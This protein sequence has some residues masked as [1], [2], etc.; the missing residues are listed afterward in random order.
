MRILLI[1]VLL[2][3]LTIAQTDPLLEAVKENYKSNGVQCS[4]DVHIEV[5]GLKMPDKQLFIKFSPDSKPV[6]KGEGMMLVPKKGLLGQFNEVL[7][8]ESQ[9]IFLGNQGD[10]ALYKIVSLNSES[11]W[12]TADVKIYRPD[13]RIYFMDIF[14]KEYGSF[15]VRHRYGQTVMPTVSVITFEAEAFKLPVK[16]LGRGN[17]E[18]LPTD[19]DG[20]VRGRVTLQYSDVKL[21]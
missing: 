11:D 18:D 8:E 2:P 4:V 16:F 1:I 12:V 21:L 13:K 10:T 14:T 6:I 19:K 20:K 9:V 5:P 17:A 15:K 3:L 7:E